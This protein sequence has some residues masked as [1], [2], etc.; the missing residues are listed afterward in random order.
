MGRIKD[1]Q[2]SLDYDV[3][4][5]E[6]FLRHNTSMFIQDLSISKYSIKNEYLSLS[7]ITEVEEDITNFLVNNITTFRYRNN[8]WSRRS[9]FSDEI[10]ELIETISNQLINKGFCVFE[11]IYDEGKLARLKVVVGEYKIKR[12][13]IIQ[14]IPNDIA[15][16]IK[17]NTRV[18]IPKEKCFILEFPKRLCS[19]KDYLYILKKMAEIDAKY[20]MFSIL[21]PSNLSKVNGYDAMKHRYKLD[22]ALRQLTKKISWH[23]RAQF[24]SRDKFSNYYS[25]LKSLKFRRTKII[26]LNHI[27]DFIKSIIEEI[28]DGTTLDISYTKSLD[29]INKIIKDYEKGIFT[30][31][32]HLK[33]IKEFM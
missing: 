6:N 17:S 10:L 23:H 9:N 28:F 27:F 25:T 8:Y 11:K 18:F 14:I 21:N 26:L 30:N 12:N 24:S 20:P 19:S 16:K 15:S 31:D 2:L 32:Q 4:R 5:N 13:N 1:G 3:P 29:E 22:L 33:I 7:L